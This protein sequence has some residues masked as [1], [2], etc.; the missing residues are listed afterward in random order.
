MASRTTAT[1]TALAL[2]VALLRQGADLLEGIADAQFTGIGP[3]LRHCLDFYACFLRGLP[4]RRIDYVHRDR[5]GRIETDR[6]FAL[7]ELL[8]TI[9]ALESLDA[10]ACSPA[11]D[12]RA[13]EGDDWAGSTPAR[14]A[15]FLASHTIHHFAIVAILLRSAGIEP[16]AD[17]GV[18]P[19]TLRAWETMA[20]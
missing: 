11:L 3:Q 13:E 7:R 8:G 5:S 17:F 1:S 14:E 18:A 9:D 2:N 12:V 20:S 6:R 10:G 19:S 4:G 16:P 15:Q